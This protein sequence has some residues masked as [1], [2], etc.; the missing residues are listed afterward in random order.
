MARGFTLIELAV[1]T[2]V[3]ALLLGSILTPLHTQVERRQV[4]ETQRAMED[5]KQALIG[6]AIANGHLPCPDRTSGGTGTMHDTAN[7]GVEDFDTGTGQCFSTTA[8]GNIPWVTL[9]LG[10]ADSWNNRFRYRV[11]PEFAR[12][13][14]AA[15]SPFS[16]A[17]VGNLRVCASSTTCSTQ[18]LTPSSPNGAV[19]VIISHGANGYGAINAM[20][21]ELRPLPTSPDEVHNLGGLDYT[22]RDITPA[23]SAAGEFDDIVTWLGKYTLFTRMVAAGRLP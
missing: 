8:S 10:A 18:P 9:G 17:S 20:N 11:A 1:A 4:T 2:A 23:G 12:R 16:F 19:A 5:I 14:P 7:D 15:S 6:F 22:S 13:P 21:N 3:V